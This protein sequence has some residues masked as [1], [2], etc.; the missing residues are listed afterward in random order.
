MSDITQQL[1]AQV[2]RAFQA[3]NPLLIRGGGS[4]FFYG[5]ACDG[6]VFAAG[7]HRGI[8]EYEPKELVITARAGTPLKDIESTLAQHGQMLAFE[9]PHFGETATLGGTIACGFSG[10]RRAFAGSAR[11]FVLGCKVLTGKGEVIEFGGKVIKNVA[12]YDVSRL[13]AG[14]L[15]TLGVILEVSLKVLPVPEAE[16]T[17]AIAAH[18]NEAIDIMNARAGQPL[19]LSGAV[20]DGEAVVMRFSSTELGI[21]ELR[22]KIAGDELKQGPEFWRQVKEQQHF[23]FANDMPL[24]RLSLAPATLPLGLPGSWLFDWGGALRWLK[25]DASP[26]DVRDAVAAEGGHATL[27]KH[28]EFWERQQPYCVFHPLPSALMAIHQKLKTA[29]DPAKILNRHRLYEDRI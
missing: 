3:N 21:K 2:Q 27:F 19:P 8:I 11:D 10:P 15:G 23:F 20:Y 28:R 7:E 24:W 4:K 5:N 6:E 13:M 9:P 29:F 26:R 1:Q 17:L 12:G 18:T 16:T 22:K 14:A 25:T